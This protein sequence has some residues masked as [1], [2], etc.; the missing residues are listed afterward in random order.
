[1]YLVVRILLFMYREFWCYVYKCKCDSFSMFMLIIYNNYI[2]NKYIYNIFVFCVIRSFVM[3][4]KFNFFFTFIY[5][6]HFYVYLNLITFVMFRIVLFWYLDCYIHMCLIPCW[7]LTT[8]VFVKEFFLPT[9]WSIAGPDVFFFYCWM[10]LKLFDKL[11]DNKVF[12]V[13]Q[14]WTKYYVHMKGEME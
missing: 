9:F 12:H 2:Y 4:M 13:A 3:L 8:C 7:R 6:L 1:M 5:I 11:I 14:T 10:F